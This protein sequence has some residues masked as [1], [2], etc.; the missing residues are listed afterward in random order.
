[1]SATVA[2]IRPAQ[3]D[4]VTLKARLALTLASRACRLALDAA[5][6]F[7]ILLM[8]DYTAHSAIGMDLA[9]YRGGG[10]AALAGHSVY[11]AWFASGRFTY[12]PFAAVVFA[13]LSRVSQNTAMGYWTVGSLLATGALVLL[14]IRFGC[15]IVVPRRWMLHVVVL[16]GML[17]AWSGPIE[18]CLMEGQIG[19]FLTLMCLAD[20][21]LPNPRWKRG[22]LI[23][24]A[25]AFKMTPGLFIVYFAVTRQ[26]KALRTSI[27]TL[28]I[29]WIGAAA[30]LPRD[31]VDFFLRGIGFDRTRIGAPRDHFDQSL[32]GLWHRIGAPGPS[33][34]WIASALIVVVFG[35]RRAR[36]A[37]DSNDL[38]AAA[39]IVGLVVLLVE[40]ISWMHH[41]AWVIPAVLLFA[42]SRDWRFRASAIAAAAFLAIPITLLAGTAVLANGPFVNT[43]VLLY[44]A[45]LVAVPIVRTPSASPGGVT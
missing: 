7:G 12:P 4:L 10:R 22:I 32:D 17:A 13:P 8:A 9:I 18:N 27:I 30:I 38:M 37:H 20:T 5:L 25:T 31:T 42:R 44:L 43:Y 1:M 11:N 26:W 23:G 6:V 16:G 24:L 21:G 34:W 28:A 45:F 19:V 14:T 41:A 35:L 40:P 36:Q 2:T 3:V 29:C 39:V 15:G 33:I